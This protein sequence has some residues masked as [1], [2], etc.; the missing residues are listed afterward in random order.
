MSK[1]HYLWL[2]L[3]HSWRKWQ[4]CY[5][6][7][8]SD[9]RA[10]YPFILFSSEGWGKNICTFSC[11]GCQSNSLQIH[12]C[13]GQRITTRL[14][15]FWTQKYNTTYAL[16]ETWMTT[17]STFQQASYIPLFLWI[18]NRNKYIDFYNVIP[19]FFSIV[20]GN[21]ISWYICC[22]IHWYMW[23]PIL[24]CSWSFVRSNQ[25]FNCSIFK[26][27]WATHKTVFLEICPCYIHILE[28]QWLS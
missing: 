12:I 9:D 4:F 18:A 16:N 17:F 1:L 25:F 10:Y 8:A 24:M 20:W 6:K 22:W 7:H 15:A 19:A 21:S 3:I 14:L 11:T 5:L 13:N 2:I 26:P 27:Q 28:M 23:L